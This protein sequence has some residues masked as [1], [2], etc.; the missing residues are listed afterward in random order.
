MLELARHATGFTNQA[1]AFDTLNRLARMSSSYSP[2]SG[3]D[4][5]EW[6]IPV[7]YTSAAGTPVAT[8]TNSSASD[9]AGNIWVRGKDSGAVEF[10]GAGSSDAKTEALTSIAAQTE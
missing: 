2:I 3:T 10:V 4:A 7:T 8:G 6:T 5:T 1:A 9:Q